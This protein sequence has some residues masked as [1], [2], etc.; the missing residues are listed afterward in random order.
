M[1]LFANH[2]CSRYGRHLKISIVRGLEERSP[3]IQ[4]LYWPIASDIVRKSA[5]QSRIRS[6]QSPLR[7]TRRCL[8]SLHDLRSQSPMNSVRQKGWMINV[9]CA[10]SWGLHIPINPVYAMMRG[11]SSG[12]YPDAIL[13]GTRRGSSYPDE[14]TDDQRVSVFATCMSGHHRNSAAIHHRS[15]LKPCQAQ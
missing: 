6:T 13:Y 10:K 4:R 3:L 5:C 8:F 2:L 1:F 9:I 14:L 15:T 12:S 7:Y 11:Y